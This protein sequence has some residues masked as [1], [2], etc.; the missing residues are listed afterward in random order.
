MK[1]RKT[2]LSL[3]LIG[4]LASGHS[5]AASLTLDFESAT[6]TSAPTG[7][8][9]I[10]ATDNGSYATTDTDG[11]GGSNGGS[12]DWT[13]PNSVA[14]TVYLVNSG[15]AFDATKSI[16]GT[17]DFYVVEDG[18][19]SAANFL[20]GDVQNGLTKTSGGD[21]LNVFLREKTFG[22]RAALYDGANTSLVN[23]ASNDREIFTNQWNTATFTWTPTSGTTGNFTFSWVRPTNI[24]EP[25]L[26]IP[27]Y[28]FDSA[29]VYFGFG[30]GQSP[31][32]FDNISITGTAIPEPRA[33]LLGGLGLLALL[34]RRR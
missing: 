29:N 12:L 31:V 23:D 14:P 26:S 18:N 3:L 32:R 22:A 24:T 9:T 19:Y 27:D 34:R 6:G 17:F 15:A 16:S 33:A 10:G 28:T 13:G 30:T 5:H 2:S 21:F 4:L 20:V 11:V 1:P 8:A 25:G 7:W